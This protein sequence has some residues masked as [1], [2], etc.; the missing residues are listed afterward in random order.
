MFILIYGHYHFAKKRVVIDYGNCPYCGMQGGL[1]RS[2]QGF[3]VGHAYFLPLLPMGSDRIYKRCACGTAQ[4]FS[5]SGKRLRLQRDAIRSEGMRVLAYGPLDALPALEEL[6]HLGDDEGVRELMQA[7]LSRQDKV[8][9]NIIQGRVS[10]LHGE[11]SE[12]KALYSTAVNMAPTSAEARLRLGSCLFRHRGM[13]K[14]ALAEVREACRLRPERAIDCAKIIVWAS[15]AH[16]KMQDQRLL[17][18]MMEEA[19]KMDPVV[20]MEQRFEYI[21]TRLRKKYSPKTLPQQAK[22]WW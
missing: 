14:G 16:E 8:A 18:E 21:L 5:L 6:V 13:Q 20:M 19:S 11:I 9:A 4:V 15:K 12:A 22:A 3:R 2:Y 10:E 7:M 17:W 1:L